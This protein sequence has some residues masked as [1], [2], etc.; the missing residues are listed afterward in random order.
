MK[1]KQVL[2]LN[3]ISD[4]HKIAGL[5][6]PEHPL[7]SVIDYGLVDYQ[8]DDSEIS[9]LQHFYCIGL[10]HDMKGRF[11]YGHQQYDFEGGI[12]SM[13]SPGQLV[14]ITID[15]TP[16]KPTGIIL[17]LHPDFL[18]NNPMAKKIKEYDYFGYSVNE[19]LFVSEKE[20]EVIL[21][22]LQKMKQEYHNNIDAFSQ[23]IILAHLEVLLNYFERFYQRQFITRQKSNHLILEKL[24]NLLNSYF[25]S[26]DL[27]EKGLPQAQDIASELNISTN[28][29]GTLLKSLTGQTT[30]QHIHSK[31]IETAKEKLSTTKL[32]VSEIAFE[33]GFEHSQSFN[34]LFKSKTGVT[35]LEYRSWN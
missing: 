10:K 25:R 13:V 19:A 11:R 9:W 27:A 2:V 24:E 12:V 20:E 26:G 1:N 33:L 28:Y 31:L 16:P 4:F 30:L 18:W 21:D 23:G 15:K 3:S 34:R 5:P 29:L 6:A 14:Q 8:T 22:V 32:S 35:P 7:V 17:C